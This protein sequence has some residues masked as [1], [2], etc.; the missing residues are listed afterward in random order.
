M[1]SE[2]VYYELFY[3]W[4]HFT[5]IRPRP[6]HGHVHYSKFKIPGSNEALCTLNTQEVLSRPLLQE[7]YGIYS[8]SI[9]ITTP[10]LQL[11]I[12]K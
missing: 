3:L 9:L 6:G 5:V 8:S 12:F 4:S 2:V 11:K 7:A 10:L 1:R